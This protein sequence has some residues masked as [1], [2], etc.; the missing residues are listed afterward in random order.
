MKMNYS[1]ERSASSLSRG[2]C[3]LLWR[4]QSNEISGITPSLTCTKGYR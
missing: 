1:G 2:T 4:H 3:A